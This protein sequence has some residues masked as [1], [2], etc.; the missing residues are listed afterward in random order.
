MLG[1]VKILCKNSEWP[2][3]LPKYQSLSPFILSKKPWVLLFNDI[4]VLR[5][6]PADIVECNV[7]TYADRAHMIYLDVR[8]IFITARRLIKGHTNIVIIPIAPKSPEIIYGP[9]LGSIITYTFLWQIICRNF[10]VLVSGELARC[11]QY[12]QWWVLFSYH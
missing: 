9:I 3:T 1:V 7:L 11:L 2:C 4:P 12:T 5:L 10:P 8:P 6:T